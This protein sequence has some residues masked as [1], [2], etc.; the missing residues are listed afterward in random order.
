MFPMVNKALF[1]SIYINP[2]IIKSRKNSIKIVQNILLGYIFMD[3]LREDK[4]LNAII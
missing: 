4:N 3:N 2:K 1:E